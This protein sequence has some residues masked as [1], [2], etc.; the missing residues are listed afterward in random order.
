M[1]CTFLSLFQ[2]AIDVNKI[3]SISQERTAKIIPNAIKITTDNEI[4]RIITCSANSYVLPG[5]FFQ[6]LLYLH[7]CGAD[8]ALIIIDC[9]TFI[10]ADVITLGTIYN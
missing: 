1:Q 5:D 9:I 2:V 4:V 3:Q 8:I 7:W 6:A 10:G